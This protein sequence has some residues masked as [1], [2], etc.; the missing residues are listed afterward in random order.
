M[1]CYCVPSIFT[2]YPQKREIVHTRLSLSRFQSHSHFSCHFCHPHK[3][4][5]TI[6]FMAPK[7]STRETFIHTAAAT[8][9]ELSDKYLISFHR[10]LF[11]LCFMHS[12][13]AISNRY[14]APQSLSLI[15]DTCHWLNF[16]FSL[17]FSPLKNVSDVIS[18]G[19]ILFAVTRSDECKRYAG[20]TEVREGWN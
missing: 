19:K 3:H 6:V 5:H 20:R 8:P 16:S 4:T 17:P 11:A 13:I 7:T 12:D 2:L 14:T 10:M 18:I 1:T 9:C 15:N